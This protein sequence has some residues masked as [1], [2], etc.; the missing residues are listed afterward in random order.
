MTHR[1]PS[2]S[3]LERV[4]ELS[5]EDPRLEKLIT[6]QAV[7]IAE[8]Q[9]TIYV[10]EELL[11]QWLDLRAES[12]GLVGYHLNGDIATWDEFDAPFVTETILAD[13]PA[14]V[15]ARQADVLRYIEHWHGISCLREM[16]R[17]GTRESPIM[18]G[19]T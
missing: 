8:L 19:R 14:A 7:T 1:N 17:N 2:V 5:I 11:R 4:Y 3:E 15:K 13:R 6:A 18:E 12:H 16:G 10:M 9:E